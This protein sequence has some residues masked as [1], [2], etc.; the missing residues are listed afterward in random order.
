VFRRVGE[1]RRGEVCEKYKQCCGP[2]DRRSHVASRT[3]RRYLERPGQNLGRRAEVGILTIQQRA[4]HQQPAAAADPDA[5]QS[6][7]RLSTAMVPVTLAAIM[8]P[9]SGTRIVS[10]WSWV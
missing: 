4:P 7:D 9:A 3:S 2:L 8:D 10:W 1:L 5:Q 6:P